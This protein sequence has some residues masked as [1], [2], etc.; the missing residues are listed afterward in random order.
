MW[1][2]WKNNL[3]HDISNSFVKW[4][5]LLKSIIHCQVLRLIFSKMCTSESVCD[6]FKQHD[7]KFIH[8]ST[9]SLG[10][11]TIYKTCIWYSFLTFRFACKSILNQ[12]IHSS[13]WKLYIYR[14]MFCGIRMI[15]GYFIYCGCNMVSCCSC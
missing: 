4:N 9:D 8:I 13:T 1:L 5:N 10:V 3:T 12:N 15:S 7:K 14:I 11:F 6:S 2:I